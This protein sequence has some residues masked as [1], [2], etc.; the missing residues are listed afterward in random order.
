MSKK[1][2]IAEKPSLAKTIIKAVGGNG[3]FKDY[4][5]NNNYVITSQFGH[6]LE[7]YSIGDYENDPERDRKWT[8]DDLP[9]FPNTFKYKIKNDKGVKDRYK[10]IKELIKR[11]DIDEII[12][13]GDPDRE[14]ETLVNIV[15]YKIFDELKLKKKVTRIWLDPLTEEKVREELKN[16]KPIENTQRLFE[17]GKTRAYLD[18]LYGM[19]LTEYNSLKSGITLNTGRVIIPLVKAIYDRDK[20]I[21]NFVPKNYFTI[22]VKITKA[23]KE[24]SLNFKDLKFD[25]LKEEDCKA[26]LNRLK[27]KKVKVLNISQKEQESKPK[28]LFSLSTLQ[29]HLFKKEKFPIAKTLELVQ[30]LYEK[31][32]L[33]Y[34]RTDTEYLSEEEKDKVKNILLKLN[35]SDLEFKDTKNI[36]NSSKVESHTAI[37]ITTNTP[38]LDALSKEEKIVYLTVRNRFF[39]NF[40]K[41]KCLLN[42]TEII[43]DLDGYK[44]KLIG[45]TIKQKGYLIYENDIGESEIPSF[46]LNEEFTPN[47]TIEKKQTTPPSHLSEADLVSFCKNPF[48]EIKNNE[49]DT[50]EENDDEEYKKI[51]EGSQIGTEATRAIMIEKIKKVGYI[52]TEKNKLIITDLGIKFIELL[53]K[54]NEDLWKEKTAQMNKDL[55]AVSKGTLSSEEV[56]KKAEDEIKSIFNQK[57][58]VQRISNNINKESLG[59]CPVCGN[60]IYENSKAYG[61]S[62]WKNG[63]KF[64]IWKKM[65]NKTITKSIAKELLKN[66]ETK[67]IKGFKSKAGKTFNAKLFIDNDKISF[68]F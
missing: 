7:L 39:A 41:E 48:K 44:T 26:E 3:G 28:K 15:V 25:D 19:N 35:N 61:C 13:A 49:E 63:C 2:I 42:K 24:I 40:T 14:G 5:E 47:L 53:E 55:K 36:F 1:L 37:I 68:K 60:D 16:P 65:A 38:N 59:K 8:L 22:P 66:K 34:P 4:Y 43:F 46:E 52:S 30:S 54:L 51:M 45:T 56:I 58:E 6:L 21:N 57:I 29:A 50:I 32:F 20:E 64:V 33:T 17:E 67:I 31:G 27:N 10:V 9:Y 62:N 23:Q 11:S 18:W 12:N